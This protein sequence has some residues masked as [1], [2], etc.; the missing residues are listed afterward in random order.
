MIKAHIIL[1]VRD[2]ESS[3]A[4]YRRALDR[5]PDL[6]VP[7]MTEFVLSDGCILGLMPTAG[8]RRLLGDVLPDPAEADGIPRCELYLR[9]ED[10][11]TAHRRALEAG[12]VELSG[13][14]ERSWGDLAAY[15]LDPDGHVLAF[16]R[17]M[18]AEMDMDG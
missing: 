18:G 12:A 17:T 7:G 4:F 14:Q 1:Y 11:A 5:T 8:I 16:A 2:Q 9:V 3:T 10:P 15:S 13:L 6:H